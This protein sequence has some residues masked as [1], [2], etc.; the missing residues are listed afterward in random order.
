M[1]PRF[2]LV[3]VGLILGWSLLVA[4]GPAVAQV[5]PFPGSPAEAKEAPSAQKG[6]SWLETEAGSW[7]R[8]F[9]VRAL[10]GEGH[11]AAWM[12]WLIPVLAILVGLGLGR[13][14]SLV[15]AAL[16]RRCEARGWSVQQQ[17][18]SGLISPASVALFAVGL[19]VATANVQ[20]FEASR[21]FWER[22][23]LLL[24][25]IAILWYASNLVFIVELL[26]RRLPIGA[27]SAIDRSLGPL[28]RKTM[29]AVLWIIGV[30]FILNSVFNQDIG[31]LLATLGIAGLAISLA[32]QDSLK[33]L[34][35]SVTIVLDR[36]FQVGERIVY[37]DFD[38][39]IE[40]IGLRSTKL[41]T[42]TGHVVTIP[43]SNIVNDPIEN[44]GQR[45]SIRR[46]M[47]VTITYDT[48][49]EKIKE[50]VQIIRAILEEEGIRE[51]IHAI[52]NGDE[53]PPRVYFNDYNAESLNIFVI[54]W[55]VPPAYWDYLDHA[56]RLNLRLF[57]EFEKAGIEFAF[58]T[59]TV[60]LAHDAKRQLVV[61]MLNRGVDQPS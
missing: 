14:S 28:L 33:N 35:G 34:I 26:L 8:F 5:A 54:Y 16:A 31:A 45:P 23:V 60:Y 32:A 59:Q 55:Y 36:P 6:E 17:A 7:L 44:I 38:G 1:K 4:I 43:N 13:I 42:L 30:L 15:L 20:V 11:L 61:E 24:F 52:I 50:A 3:L 10:W 39:V 51:P 25:C 12:A 37:K 18:L 21:L 58:P 46:I 56:Q 9:D 27:E 22:A 53:F 40:E 2:T 19:A 49:L 47:N 57:E 41:R 48:P 29:R